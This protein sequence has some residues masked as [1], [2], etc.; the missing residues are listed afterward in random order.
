M[1]RKIDREE[2]MYGKRTSSKTLV[3]YSDALVK[4]LNGDLESLK[5][6]EKIKGSAKFQQRTPN[7][8]IC[9]DCHFNFVIGDF[10][11]NGS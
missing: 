7:M 5:F 4:E 8:K 6:P 2:P 3:T 11:S 10:Q 1:R 9:W